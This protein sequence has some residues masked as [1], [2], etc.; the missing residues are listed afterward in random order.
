M[1]EYVYCFYVCLSILSRVETRKSDKLICWLEYMFF[2]GLACSFI[3]KYS[4][5]PS[6]II[7]TV[8]CI[9]LLV[10]HSTTDCKIAPGRLLKDS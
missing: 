3:F 1:C 7:V 6:M 5:E 2:R 10:M 9:F 8:V 4:S